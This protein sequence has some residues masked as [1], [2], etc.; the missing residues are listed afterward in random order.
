M[1]GEMQA[2]KEMEAVKA[3][4]GERRE[5]IEKLKKEK[6]DKI[7]HLV[8]EQIRLYVPKFLVRFYRKRY[9]A[10]PSRYQISGALERARLPVTVPRFMA[11]AQFYALLSLI[12]GVLLGYLFARAILPMEALEFFN[13]HLYAMYPFSVYPS[14][15]TILC[16]IFFSIFAYFFVRS[17]ILSYPYYMGN[18]RK[19]KIENAIPHTVNMLLGMARGG[20]PLSASFR[21]IAENRHIFDEASRE[22]GK[23]VELMDVFGYD[24]QSAMRYV[25]QT[26]PSEKFSNFLENFLNVVESGGNIVEYLKLKSEQLFEERE[27]YHALFFETLQLIAEIYLAMFIITPLFFLTVLVVFQILQGGILAGYKVAL[28]TFLPIGSIMIIYLILG[29][30]PK[31][32]R[33]SFVRGQEIIEDIGVRVNEEPGGEYKIN[34]YRRIFNRIK[35]FLVTPFRE[36]IYSLTLRAISVYLAIPPIVF[37][38]LSYGRIDFESMLIG[39]VISIFI[40]LVI[41][42]EYRERVIRK[43]ESQIPDFLRQ[44]AGLNEAGLNVVEALKHV[45]TMEM[46]TLNREIVKIRRDVEWGELVTEALRKLETRV[47]SAVISRVVSLVVKAVESTPSI[48]EALY[49]ASV[50]SEIEIEARNRIR[51]QMSMYTIIIYIAFFV[52]LYTTYVLLNNIMSIFQSIEN[53]PPGI[54][55]GIDLKMLR[56]TFYQTTLLVGFFSGLTAGVMGEG[57]IEAG[58]KH[59]IVFVLIGYIFFTRIIVI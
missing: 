22:F 8:H 27:K 9:D 2:K 33:A 3:H 14:L 36:V 41:F 21:F 59:V 1:T 17:S 13:I 35:A 23:I 28:F 52:F 57:K 16:I 34:K 54:V 32:P 46:G 40:P 15:Y 7:N 19:G 58:L 37:I 25:S 30:M 29:M 50:Y 53:L 26:T 24:M 55:A 6:K 48:K 43:I 5:Y 45:S 44:L 11:I 10:D 49:T 18:I 31:E 20:V 38:I 51:G 42:L 39:T 4:D 56:D 47:R 12:P